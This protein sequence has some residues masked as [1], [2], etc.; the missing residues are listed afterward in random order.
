M[1]H[2]CICMGI[3]VI[4]WFNR[5]PRLSIA[6]VS[7]PYGQRFITI[8]IE[9]QNNILFT[10]PGNLFLRLTAEQ[11]TSAGAAKGTAAAL[12]VQDVKKVV[13]LSPVLA[14]PALTQPSKFRIWSCILTTSSSTLRLKRD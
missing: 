2:Y 12:A 11:Q 10:A 4:F 5:D 9:N 1:I 3:N 7:I 8:D 14:T 13:T 6:S